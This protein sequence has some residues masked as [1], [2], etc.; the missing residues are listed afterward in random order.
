MYDNMTLNANVNFFFFVLC[1]QRSKVLVAKFYDLTPGSFVIAFGAKRPFFTISDST[2]KLYYLF[3]FFF[4]IMLHTWPLPKT[5]SAF[6]NWSLIF[7]YKISLFAGV[8][9]SSL[10]R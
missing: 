8:S 3:Q 9:F 5:V 10:H 4:L 7:L 6:A 1:R 2:P